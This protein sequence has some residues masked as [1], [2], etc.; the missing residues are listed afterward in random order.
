MHVLWL[1]HSSTSG[2]IHA[3]SPHT[4]VS[5]AAQQPATQW[6]QEPRTSSHALSASCTHTSS[7]CTPV[8]SNQELWFPRASQVGLSPERQLVHL[9]VF[10]SRTQTHQ[11][12]A[13][14]PLH[15]LPEQQEEQEQLQE[16]QFPDSHRGTGW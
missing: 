11:E 3:R 4:A 14:Q 9:L 5:V 8:Q 12:A 10:V 7:A 2:Q 16:Q 1:I 15:H 13:V 6:N